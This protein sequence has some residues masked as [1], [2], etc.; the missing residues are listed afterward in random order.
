MITLQLYGL[1]DEV[2]ASPVMLF[3]FIITHKLSFMI[4]AT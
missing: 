4:H 1:T 2:S 3:V